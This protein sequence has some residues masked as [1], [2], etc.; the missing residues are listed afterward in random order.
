MQVLLGCHHPIMAI[1]TIMILYFFHE[2]N[3]IQVSFIV[4]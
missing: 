4:M 3:K 1:V 2:A